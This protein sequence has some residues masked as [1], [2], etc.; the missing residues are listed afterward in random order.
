M[1]AESLNPEEE[2]TVAEEQL[3]QD[4]PEE[5]Q[6]RKPTLQLGAGSQRPTPPPNYFARKEQYR[7]LIL[8]SMLMLVLVMMNE[9]RKP[10][11]WDW[12]WAGDANQTVA[13]ANQQDQTPIDTRV[14]DRRK[15][16]VPANAFRVAKRDQNQVANVE[17]GEAML[18][19]ITPEL[20]SPIEDNS[21]LRVAENDAWQTVLGVLRDTPQDDLL[22]RSVGNVSF[23]QLFRQ[24]EIYRGRVVSIRGTIRRA[25]RITTRE[26]ENGIEALFRWIVEP[27]GPSNAPIV[28]YSLDKPAEFKVTDDL[29]EDAT[30][31]G[32]FFKRWAYA[33]GDGTRIAPLILAKTASWQ[34]KPPP[35]PVKLPAAPIV[36][37]T[38]A[39]LALLAT[40]IAAFVYR[41]SNAKHPDVERARR[42]TSRDVDKL[43]DSDVLPSV[44]QSL[45]QLAA[46][47]KSSGE[48]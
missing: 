22:A 38:L 43:D 17:H 34:P 2:R 39:G 23:A 32:V 33:A 45:Q 15:P 47:A 3:A 48:E 27:A 24:T 25:E 6:H 19:S 20:L 11:M 16:S 36:A 30:F 9:V 40:G 5:P 35:T 42:Y 1:M 46:E 8:C 4:R 18:P 14:K 37:A 31:T 13:N 28:I 26:N 44:A 29:R 12:M 21:I 10:E 7:L 41:N